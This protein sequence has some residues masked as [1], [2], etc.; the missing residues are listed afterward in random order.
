MPYSSLSFVLSA[1]LLAPTVALAE[2]SSG[3]PLS[4]HYLPRT[5]H[6]LTLVVGGDPGNPL[7]R[8]RLAEEYSRTNACEPCSRFFVLTAQYLEGEKEEFDAA[9]VFQKQSATTFQIKP[10]TK[11]RV[12]DEIITGPSKSADGTTPPPQ[13]L[14][15]ELSKALKNDFTAWREVAEKAQTAIEKYGWH[16]CGLL[17]VLSHAWLYG[18]IFQREHFEREKAELALRIV[19]QNAD[20]GCPSSESSATDLYFLAST[21]SFQ[22][23]HVSAFVAAGLAVD[24][25]RRWESTGA[26]TPESFI[27]RAI[28]FANRL[29]KL[30]RVHRQKRR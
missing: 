28:D 6:L 8:V 15:V 13:H 3:D 21:L 18:W 30:A 12:W 29:E 17:R 10:G 19:F 14:A 24:Y 26:E 20:A 5:S 2:S 9:R 7:L 27:G 22:G 25:A 4:K 23:D 1:F 16:D 11:C